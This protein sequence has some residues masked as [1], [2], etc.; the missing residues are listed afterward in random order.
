MTGTCKK[1]KCETVT[2]TVSNHGID[3]T[4][5]P[6]K[7]IADYLA[8]GNDL[9]SLNIDGYRVEFGW[10]DSAVTLQDKISEIFAS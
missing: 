7:R 5:E 9:D 2:E 6:M 10:I 3:T 1:A 4:A 8:K